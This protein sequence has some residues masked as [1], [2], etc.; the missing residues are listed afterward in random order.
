MDRQCEGLSPW[1]KQETDSC[2][3]F[4][5]YFHPTELFI[6]AESEE[7]IGKKNY[8]TEMKTNFLLSLLV[9]VLFGT[10]VMAQSSLLATLNHEGTISTFY[11][12][13]AL[14]QAHSAAVEGDVVTLSSGTFASVNITKAITLRGAGMTLD[15]STQTEPTVL[16][17]DFSIEIPD[18]ST[19]RLTI[20]GI[21][22]NQTITIKKLKNALFLKDRM[23]YIAVNSDCI[24]KDLTFI[25]CRITYYYY[26]YSSNNSASFQNC[27]LPSNIS[28]KNYIFK[29][30]IIGGGGTTVNQC[31]NSEYK[32]CIIMPSQQTKNTSTYYNNMFIGNTDISSI[33]NKTN[34]KVSS[35]D[36][37]L[38][39]VKFSVSDDND[40]KLTDEAKAIMKGTDGTEVGI[41]GGSLP[42][43]PT[44]TN[45]QISKF[46]VAAKTTADGKLSVDIE[47]KSAE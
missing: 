28:G 13:N 47:V 16:A 29:N 7:S 22:S 43:D 36:E 33:T 23:Y 25:H 12:T 30:C 18:E 4:V 42:Y 39:G 32:N 27:V 24:A 35:D 37:R 10:R 19:K 38:N 3:F 26:C 6:I 1:G 8:Q 17:N 40:Y 34:V 41:Y 31:D 5:E 14:Q 11:G 44:P 46:N 45:P 20:E 2:A 15:A 21:Y 9:L